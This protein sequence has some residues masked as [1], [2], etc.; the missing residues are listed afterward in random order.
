MIHQHFMLVPSQTVT[1]NIILGLSDPRFFLP[2]DKLDK[3]ILDLQEQYGLKVD[4]KAKIWQ[5]SVG[6]QQRVEILKMLYRGAK[7]LI[8]DEPTAVLTPQ[9]I[10]ELFV[11]LRAMVAG[12]HSIV[13]ISHKLHEV[14]AI[15][16]RV[17]VLRAGKVTAAA[18]STTGVTKAQLATLMVGREVVFSVKKN[19]VTAGDV[20]LSVEGACAE[21][22]RGVPA[23]REFGIQV[24]A[25]EIVGIAGVA[26]NGQS[27]LAQVITGLRKCSSG[28]VVINGEDIVNQDPR[29][30]IKR[31]VAH[32]PEDRHHVGSSPGLSLADNLIMKSYRE[33]PVS[34]GWV[35][36]RPLIREQAQTLKKEYDIAAPNIDVQVR[37]LSG[38][39][40]QK[41]IL[42]REMTAGPKL[43]VAVQPTRGL[44]VGAIEAVQ[45][46]LLREREKGTA[47]LL[48][49]EELEEIMT[50]SD[51]I[52]GIYEGQNMGELK[53]EEATLTEIGL[54]MA[55]TPRGEKGTSN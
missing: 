36:N 25:G 33:A 41:A 51:R 45:R 30:A 40:L 50:L 46:V 1:E 4:P 35:L 34:R 49:S 9:E 15:A 53:S 47:I 19:P 42:A 7:I 26:G 21:N 23:L 48:I 27:E 39:N 20:V 5:L 11:T 37:L 8:M 10:E 32:V 28:K 38:G 17:T 12:G 18:V 22:D 52:V 44:D 2:M 13:F 55:G 54:M 16:N 24:R 29:A 6:E 31:K 14:L 43:I 3:Q